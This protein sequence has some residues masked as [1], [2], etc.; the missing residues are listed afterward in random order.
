MEKGSILKHSFINAIF[1]AVYVILVTLF[2]YLLDQN[3]ADSEGGVIAMASILMLLVISVAIIG[4]LLFGRP[5]MWYVDGKK[6][7][8]IILLICTLGIFMAITIIF[9]LIL[10]N[11]II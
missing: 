6:K 7:E 10:L 1:T 8:A 5:A 4:S 9:L 3:S 2:I 11:F